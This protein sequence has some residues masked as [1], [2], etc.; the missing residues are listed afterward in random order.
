M[1]ESAHARYRD[2]LYDLSHDEVLHRALREQLD[3]GG[4]AWSR[5]HERFLPGECPFASIVLAGTR[6]LDGN[7]VIVSIDAFEERP[8]LEGRAGIAHVPRVGWLCTTVF[9]ADPELT[10]LEEVLG[11]PGRSTVVKYHP[12]KRCTIRLDGAEGTRFA[13]VFRPRRGEKLHTKHVVMWESAQRSELGFSIPRPER[14]DPRTGALWLSTVEGEPAKIPLF[15]AGGEGLAYTI[16]RAAASFARSEAALCDVFGAKAQLRRSERHRRD[17]VAR[18]PALGQ[19]TAELFDRLRLAHGSTIRREARPIHG[20]LHPPQWLLG[21]S[22]LGLIDLDSVAFG[23]PELDAATFIADVDIQN[24][25]RVP[26]A[27]IAQAFLSG[28]ESLGEKLDHA[29]LQTYRAHKHLALAARAARAVKPD[30][31]DRAERRL[32][33]AARCLDVSPLIRCAT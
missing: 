22:G 14:F 11:T 28:Y 24:P 31:D 8:G 12:G 15:S 25:E 6:E 26:T 2:R 13:K 16:G 18:V 4:V 9:P 29:L 27:S 33:R 10:A 23:D 19:G 32:A 17:L 3:V 20:A 5:I 7:Q 1:S 30:G 21:P